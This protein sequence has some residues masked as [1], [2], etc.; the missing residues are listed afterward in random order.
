MLSRARPDLM[1][2]AKDKEQAVFHLFRIYDLKPTIH[3]TSPFPFLFHA[4]C[5]ERSLTPLTKRADDLR[6]P[7]LE[8]T[9]QTAGRKSH[10]PKKKA[11]E[12]AAAAAEEGLEDPE[13][14]A[15]RLE[16]EGEVA[17][18]LPSALKGEE[19]EGE[20][21]LP[22]KQ[23]KKRMTKK[24]KEALEEK[25]REAVELEKKQEEREVQ[26]EEGEVKMEI[27]EVKPVLEVKE[28]EK[29]Q[30]ERPAL[31]PRRSTRS[32]VV[33]GVDG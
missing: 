19:R 25:A 30:M 2:E 3:G 24:E 18:D 27:D 10:T 7:A 26:M 12:A 11:K 31:A 29:E 4:L 9:K 16:D 6:P 28:V 5:A 17:V 13:E 23:R 33:A 14:G 32:S 20:V 1:I 8:E 15:S 22:Q 21:N